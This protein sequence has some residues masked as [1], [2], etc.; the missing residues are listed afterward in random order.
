MKTEDAFVSELLNTVTA[1]PFA[2]LYVL[3]A[4][5]ASFWQTLARGS[6]LAA[7][8]REVRLLNPLSPVVTLCTAAFDVQRFCVQP[9]LY[10]RVCMDNSI[11]ET[12]EESKYLGTILTNHN[13][14][15]EEIKSRLKLGNTCYHSVQ[16][17]LSSNLLSKN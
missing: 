7:F 6:I 13:S 17:L 4:F 10:L 11:F 5:C 12:V 14:I 3:L 2:A 9:L 15:Q 1:V 16:K 8:L